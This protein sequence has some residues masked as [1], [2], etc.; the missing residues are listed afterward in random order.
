M[1]SSAILCDNASAS[2]VC[3]YLLSGVDG[4]CVHSLS[5][6]GGV[7]EGLPHML[8]CVATDA[9]RKLGGQKHT[10]VVST[11][12]HISQRSSGLV[13]I[14]HLACHSWSENGLTII[15]KDQHCQIWSNYVIIWLKNGFLISNFIKIIKNLVFLWLPP[16]FILSMV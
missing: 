1:T 6:E 12:R 2:G 5:A 14:R 7:L 4:V 3:V 10:S 11:S 13:F 16:I 8:V 15:K 9:L